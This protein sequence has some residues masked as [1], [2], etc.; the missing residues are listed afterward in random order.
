MKFDLKTVQTDLVCPKSK[1]RLIHEEN[2]LVNSDEA[3]RLAYPI[4][5]QIPCMIVENAM[6]LSETEW[7]SIIERQGD[8]NAR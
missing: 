5:D 8:H 2:R 3:T 1:T 4:V 6:Q 7:K